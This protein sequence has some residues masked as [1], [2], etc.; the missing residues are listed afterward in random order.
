MYDQRVL[1]LSLPA[2]LGTMLM[3]KGRHADIP[4]RARYLLSQCRRIRTC[5]G[6][7]PKCPD[8]PFRNQVYCRL[9]FL[10]ASFLQAKGSESPLQV[11]EP[12]WRASLGRGGV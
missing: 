5:L 11:S 7:I 6:R 3:C 1:S 12:F 2:V 4:W 8:S 10:R 9:L